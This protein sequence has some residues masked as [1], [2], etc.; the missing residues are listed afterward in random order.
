[1][2]SRKE[3]FGLVLIEAMSFGLPVIATDAGGVPEI[4]IDGQTGILV[5][6]EDAAALRKA[7]QRLLKDDE[8]RRGMGT[9]GR[10]R[11]VQRYQLDDHM[12]R[13]VEIFQQAIGESNVQH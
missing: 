7:I 8:L 1:M 13:L 3:T 12:A 5:P 4:V 11:V 6:P 2:P 10:E 9:R